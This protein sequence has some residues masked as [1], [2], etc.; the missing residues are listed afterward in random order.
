[1]THYDPNTYQEITDDE[2]AERYN[3]YLD[4][5]GE[6]EITIDGIDLLP[7]KALKLTEPSAYWERV[8]D[9]TNSL[10]DAGE[11]ITEDSRY[12]LIRDELQDWAC[13]HIGLLELVTSEQEQTIYDALLDLYK[14]DVIVYEYGLIDIATGYNIV[15]VL[16]HIVTRLDS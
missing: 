10:Y 11:L 12:S 14:R 9:Y 16:K 2:L 4:Y 15:D 6:Y 3:T 7:S 1:M 5:S 13:D 8:N